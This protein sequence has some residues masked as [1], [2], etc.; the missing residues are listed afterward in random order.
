MTL[1][2]IPRNEESWGGVF[3]MVYCYNCLVSEILRRLRMTT[4]LFRMT[5]ATTR[6]EWNDRDPLT[7]RYQNDL[8]PHQDDR[9]AVRWEEIFIDCNKD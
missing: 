4:N 7:G 8:P 5:G 9:R 3:G 6:V 1:I 2:V